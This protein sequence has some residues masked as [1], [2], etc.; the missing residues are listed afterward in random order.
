MALLKWRSLLAC[1]ATALFAILLIT[2]SITRAK[3][4]GVFF[5]LQIRILSF[6]FAHYRSVRSVG[7][8]R[9]WINKMYLFAPFS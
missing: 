9:G 4:F 5:A 1:E 3:T 2:D 7:E 6:S 8:G